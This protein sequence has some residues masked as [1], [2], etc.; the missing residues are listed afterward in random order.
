MTWKR[1]LFKKRQWYQVVRIE[2]GWKVRMDFWVT[3]YKEHF[4][5]DVDVSLIAY[6]GWY[7]SHAWRWRKEGHAI[8]PGGLAVI[9]VAL[10]LLDDVER[11]APTKTEYK[12]VFMFVS[13]ASLKLYLAYRGILKKRGYKETCETAE[14]YGPYLEKQ[15]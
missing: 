2:D 9:P 5:A 1:T 13:G 4:D 10:K 8:G 15:L 12:D 14:E 7:G 6:R 3:P 11:V